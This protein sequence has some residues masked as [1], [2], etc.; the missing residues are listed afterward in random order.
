MTAP[1]PLAVFELR[2][3]A[4]AELYAACVF[5]DPPDAVDELQRNAERDGLV[6]GIGQDAVQRI[7]ADAFHG[8][9][10]A[11]PSWKAAAAMAWD[12]PGWEAAALEYHDRAH[13]RVAA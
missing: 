7:L 5:Y 6:D 4:R 10:A 1:D 8:T 11:Y 13:Q 3:W 2:A 9:R 12:H